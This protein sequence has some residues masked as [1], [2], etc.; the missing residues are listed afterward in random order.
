MVLGGTHAFAPSPAF[1][2]GARVASSLLPAATASDATGSSAAGGDAKEVIGRRLTVTGGV[3]GGYY[4]SCVRNEVCKRSDLILDVDRYMYT[5]RYSVYSLES[6]EQ[7]YRR[8]VIQNLYQSHTD[9]PF[10]VI[11][12]QVD[13]EI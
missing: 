11:F 12:R 4:R 6:T 13:S 8:S 3:Q 1:S 10:V 9:L 2:T 5:L 7:C